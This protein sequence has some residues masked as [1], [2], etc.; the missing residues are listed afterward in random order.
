MYVYTKKSM[1]NYIIGIFI[2]II[3]LVSCDDSRNEYLAGSSW[4][5]AD[6]RVKLID[7]LT[8]KM[9]TIMMDSVA[10][11][12]KSEI[13]VGRTVIFPFLVTLKSRAFC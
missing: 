1:K 11:S 10:T 9:S 2:I 8:L 13:L 3:G 4:A 7:T 12:G 6:S 5:T